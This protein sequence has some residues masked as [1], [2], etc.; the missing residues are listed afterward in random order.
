MAKTYLT[1]NLLSG[2]IHLYTDHFYPFTAAEKKS[3]REREVHTRSYRNEF[4]PIPIKAKE[5]RSAAVPT[6]RAITRESSACTYTYT[7]VCVSVCADYTAVV[8]LA[9]RRYYTSYTYSESEREERHASF[10]YLQQQ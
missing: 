7:C 3:E 1:Q 6:R 8:A 2:F 10:V 4:S 5:T 9:A